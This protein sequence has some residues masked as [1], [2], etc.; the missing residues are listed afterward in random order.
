MGLEGSHTIDFILNRMR[1][2]SD[3]KVVHNKVISDFQ[4]LRQARA[5]V[6]GLEPATEGSLQISGRTRKP[7]CYRRPAQESTQ[8]LGAGGELARHCYTQ[9]NDDR[10]SGGKIAVDHYFKPTRYSGQ[11]YH[12]RQIDPATEKFPAN[13]RVASLLAAPPKCL[14]EE[15]ERL[16][17]KRKLK[18][19]QQNVADIE[20]RQNP[21]YCRSTQKTEK[22]YRYSRGLIAT[23]YK[24]GNFTARKTY[25]KDMID[26][27]YKQ[28]SFTDGNT[29]SRGTIATD[30]NSVPLSL[31]YRQVVPVQRCL[32]L[33]AHKQTLA[34]KSSVN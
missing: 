18:K 22:L 20:R 11:G 8:L 32:H 2:T 15:K 21:G 5:P 29:Y 25:S 30:Y 1:C 27:D 31:Q 9:E 16:T 13:L 34:S 3:C 4:A 10:D 17:V 24:Q 14:W 28:G 23:D 7:L 12:G 19:K 33:Q 26:K 6:T